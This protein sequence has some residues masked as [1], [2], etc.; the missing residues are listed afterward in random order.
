M[1]QRARL[2]ANPIRIPRGRLTVTMES[3][4]ELRI[5]PRRRPVGTGQVQRLLPFRRRR[6]V[7]PFIFAD[8]IGPETLS[9]GSGI[10]INAH[11]HIG[12]STVTY[13]FDGRLVHRDSTGTTQTI[14]PG[15]VNWMTAG[16]GVTHTER[17]V[18]E[19]IETVT[20]LHGMQMWVALPDGAEDVT[21][22]FQHLAASDVPIDR[23]VG[24]E[25]RVA[26]GSGW[27]LESPLAGLSPLVLAEIQLDGTTA[28]PVSTNHREIAVVSISGNVAVNDEKLTTGQLAV[29]RNDI[30]SAVSGRG[31][32]VVIGGEPIGRRHI[33]WNFVSSDPQ[34]ID[35][36]KEDWLAQRF[37]LVPEDH[38]P[39][40]PLPA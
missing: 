39:H 21:A 5:E 37:P 22:S 2:S 19:D 29:L 9:P 7:G 16:S 24:A 20:S 36:A 40:V 4:I 35:Q 28:V 1:A 18:P 34:R 38:E 14:D 10:G 6:M 32:V 30:S 17:S 15:A 23:V 31:K 33:W 8:L 27:G 11:P 26:V 25:I 3:A 12:L 13:L